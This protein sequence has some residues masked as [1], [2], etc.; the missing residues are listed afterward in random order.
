M[1]N[2][3]RFAL[4][5]LSAL[6]LLSSCSDDGSGK[7]R[8]IEPVVPG[9]GDFVEN[10]DWTITYTGRSVQ[11]T[12]GVYIVDNIHVASTD[13]VRYYLDVVNGDDYKNTYGSNVGKLI[14]GS[15]ENMVSDYVTTG[16]SDVSF[17]RLADGQWV[18]VAYEVNSDGSLGK[19]YSLLQFS[20]VDFSMRKTDDF[21]ISVSPRKTASDGKT[22]DEV[23][24][25][26]SSPV[27]Y[28]VDVTYPEYIDSFEG[29]NTTEKTTAFFNSVLDNLAAGLS[30]DE[31][32][33]GLL[34]LGNSTVEFERLRSGDWTAYAFG[35]DYNGFLTGEYASYDFNLKEEEMTEDFSKWLGKWKIGDSN[36]SYDITVSN[37]EANYYYLISGWETGADASDFANENAKDYQFEASFTKGSP[38][39]TFITNYLG[40]L[41]DD[42]IGDFDVMFVGNI[43]V[44][45]A[46]GH[47]YCIV[48][49]NIPVATAKLSD[50]GNSATVTGEKVTASID[51]NNRLAT[52]ISMQF[53]DLTNDNT[54]TYNGGTGEKPIPVF[55]LSMTRTGNETIT[56]PNSLPR[57]AVRRSAP[58]ETKSASRAEGSD[59]V[60]KAYG[61][62]SPVR[63]GVPEAKNVG[64]SVR[65]NKGNRR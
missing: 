37:S 39:L 26:S 58:I 49:E 13:N 64:G 11:T 55:P 3:Y 54:Y 35:V 20:P 27:S 62:S 4:A 25:T 44:K 19:K 41:H 38:D 18:A 32:F 23:S 30:D 36:T 28:Y 46:N 51:G 61:V 12:N 7:R 10:S 57:R 50:D 6:L 63:K 60:R 45:D 8:P 17:D 48:D 31:D 40:T 5:A 1:N 56:V 9:G 21:R 24:V 22:V 42:Q 34:S 14:K 16:D 15:F 33:S 47:P 29:S 53:V 2:I 65:V 59:S 52:F 43:D